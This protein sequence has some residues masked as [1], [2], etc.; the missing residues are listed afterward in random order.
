M[1]AALI[2]EGTGATAFISIIAWDD[3]AEAGEFAEV[4]QAYADARFGG[5]RS[6][7][8]AL[9]WQGESQ[10]ASFLRAGNQTLWILAPDALTLAELQ[11]RLDLPLPQQ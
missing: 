9:T 4:F 1:Y 8:T 6:T 3:L 7:A 2:D 5:A 11:D 10:H